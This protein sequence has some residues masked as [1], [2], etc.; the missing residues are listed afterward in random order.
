MGAYEHTLIYVEAIRCCVTVHLRFGCMGKIIIP[1]SDSRDQDFFEEY[2]FFQ[3]VFHKA[4]G[5]TKETICTNLNGI[6]HS[7]LI[8]T[9]Y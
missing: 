5:E 2:H 9:D 6:K 8:N 3:L 7:C 4:N 1:N